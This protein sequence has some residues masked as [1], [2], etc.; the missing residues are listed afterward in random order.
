ML[1][2]EKA[3]CI[4]QFR[5]VAVA[6]EEGH[7]L[8]HQSVKDDFWALPGGRVELFE[9]STETVTR[10]I[11]EELG[12]TSTVVRPLWTVES[13]FEYRGKKYHEISNYFLITLKPGTFTINDVSFSGIEKHVDVVFK[14]VPLSSLQDYDIRPGFLVTGLLTLPVTLQHLC[15][16]DIAEKTA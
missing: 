4:F 12:Y 6:I 3:G 7:V 1:R 15:A 16:N 10:E 5:A 9:T 2:F 8:I 13:F 14:W 11:S